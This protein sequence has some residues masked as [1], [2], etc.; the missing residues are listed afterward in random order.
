MLKLKIILIA[1]VAFCAFSHAQEKQAASLEALYAEYEC[2]DILPKDA[3][4]LQ[5]CTHLPHEPSASEEPDRHN[6]I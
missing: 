4:W 2:E 1:L 6:H 3:S 5:D